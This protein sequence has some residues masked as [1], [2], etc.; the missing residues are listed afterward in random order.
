MFQRHILFISCAS[1]L[2]KGGI[3]INTELYSKDLSAGYADGFH[4]HNLDFS[5]PYKKITSLIGANGSGKST[6]LKAMTRLIPAKHGAV[7]LDGQS[8]YQM[9]TRDVARKLAILPQ[10]AQCP[11]GM[12]VKELVANGR[13]PH[14]NGMKGLTDE[15]HR[16]IRWAMDACNISEFSVREVD[17]LSG[18]QRQRVWISM[19]LAQKTDILFLDEPTTFLD[20]AHQLDIMHLLV[21]LNKE[22]GVTIV[23]VLHDLNHAAMFSDNIVAICNGEKYCEGSPEQV[24]VPEVLR[25]VFNVES[26]KL[27]HPVLNTPLCLPYDL[28]RNTSKEVNT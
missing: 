28:C 11:D 22:Q 7:Y 8:I 21:S 25:N 9:R 17:S 3:D 14:R 18:G 10:N 12:T 19:A 26:A 1:R 13:F 5:I 6:V 27:V 23:M 4:F 15:D 2:F 16:I 20:I 24:I